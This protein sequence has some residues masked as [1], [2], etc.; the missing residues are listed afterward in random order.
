M[1]RKKDGK[2]ERQRDGNSERR[3]DGK[4]YVTILINFFFYRKASYDILSSMNT[5]ADPCEDFY[6]V[7]CFI[8]ININ[9]IFLT[10][11]I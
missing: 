9:N 11:S 3:K 10:K 5:F 8:F 6:E 2:T 4:S 7:S 1:E